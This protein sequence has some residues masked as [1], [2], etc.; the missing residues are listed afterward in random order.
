VEEIA[1]HTRA[2]GI[3]VLLLVC[4][5][6]AGCAIGG[7]YAFDYRPA[8]VPNIG[9]GRSVTLLPAS[10]DRP[11]VTSGEEPTSYVGEQ[12]G[13]YGNPFN[14]NTVGRRPFAE[15]VTETVRRELEA[16]GFRVTVADSRPSGD[17]G[18]QVRSLGA[19]RTLVVNVREFNSNTMHNIDIEWDLEARVFDGAGAQL[20]RSNLVGKE[21]L[22]GSAWNPP[23][24]AKQKVPQF[25][26]EKV[27]Q[28]IT[29]DPQVV[30]ALTR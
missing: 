2:F 29:G 17:V 25:F 20:A 5:T 15:V 28:L 19:D 3:P 22:L 10:D 7:T 4:V 30:L 27:H 8:N 24:A 14:V 1:V 16:A 6:T 11:A 12:R 18:A 26:Y 23:K 9:S 21:S 13:G